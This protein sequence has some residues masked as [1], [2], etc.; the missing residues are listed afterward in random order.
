MLLVRVV[1]NLNSTHKL[2]VLDDSVHLLDVINYIKKHKDL[3][4]DIKEKGTKYECRAN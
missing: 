4:V 3:A 2:L 1:S